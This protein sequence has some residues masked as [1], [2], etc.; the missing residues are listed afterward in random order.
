MSKGLHVLRAVQGSVWA[1]Q[2]DKLRELA[3]VVAHRVRGGAKLTAQEMAAIQRPRVGGSRSG[4]VAV[5]PLHGVVAQRMD[6]MTAFS[7]G[8]STEAFAR[9]FDALVKDEN[10][11]A[12][13]IDIDS[14][15]GAV[16]GVPELARKIHAARGT[17]PIVAVANSLM[18]SA[19]YWIGSAADEVVATEMAFVGSVNAIMT[20]VD[21]T[22][23]DDKDGVAYHFITGGQTNN[24]AEGNPHFP[25]SDEELE[26]IQESVD[27]A[28]DAFINAVASHRN[29][30][31][32]H[33]RE[34]YGE[35]RV[36]LGKRAV[37][38]GL[39][40]R[41]STL[42]A[43]VKDLAAGVQPKRG[44]RAE[45]TYSIAA[46]ESTPGVSGLLTTHDSITLNGVSTTGN[47]TLRLVEAD[48]TDAGGAAPVDDDTPAIETAPEAGESTMSDQGTAAAASGA[49]MEQERKRVQELRALAR[50]AN[51][52]FAGSVDDEQVDNWINAGTSYGDASR[53]ARVLMKAAQKDSP[54]KPIRN[55]DGTVQVGANR[56]EQDP[57][58]GFTTHRE[59]LLATIQNAGLRDKSQVADERLRVLA[60][61]DGEDKKAAGELAYLLPE[62]FTP[63]SLR[64]AA[65]SDEQGMYDH[66]YGGAGAQKALLPGML[67]VGM[68]ADPSAGRTTSIPMAVPTVELLA[69]TDKDHTTSVS[70]GL[71]VTRR[72]ETVAAAASRQSS[73]KVTLKASGLF[74]L[75]YETE[76]VLTDSPISF[77]A[78]IAAGFSDQFAHKILSEKIRGVGGSEYLGVLNS[79]A[80]VE[81]AK[82]SGQAADTIRAL[83]ILK[84]RARVWNYSNAFWIANHD[85]YVQLAQAAIVVEG[86]T[87]GGLITVFQPSLVSDRPDMLLGRPIFFSEYASTLGDAGDIMCINW[88]QYLEGTYQP[89]Q[90]AESVHVRF[91]EH[92]RVFKMW[93]RNAGAPWW[94]AALTPHKGADTLSPIVTLAAR[95]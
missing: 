41:I 94:R 64:A 44:A 69:R 70:G 27:A 14:P 63:S 51:S 81:I 56:V 79:P 38:A 11:S 16:A 53:E 34:Q 67:S 76:E 52:L 9:E 93:T 40:D 20:R 49:A 47:V 25:V 72:P 86:S 19:A 61:T 24:K 74:G 10:I 29:I 91:V 7:G 50:D 35:G 13:V 77:A 26:A 78:I 33:V 71:T 54:V 60:V 17:K 1:I 4:A 37:D 12:I 65:G 66:R 95:A 48:T 18:A 58:K 28:Y 90:S 88:S 36:F 15:G 6:M 57:R 32:E 55:G 89:L 87:G 2:P 73:E 5:I 82:E 22:A 39:A 31:A 85:T 43:V 45:T 8:V 68:E 92:E 21:M 46:I 80:K 30:S 83:N 3:A 23:K 42:D 84:M 75:A 62:A 59:F